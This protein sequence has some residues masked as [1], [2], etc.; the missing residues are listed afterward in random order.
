ML[1]AR[2]ADIGQKLRRAAVLRRGPGQ[3]GK[4]R[5]PGHARFRTVLVSGLDA[6]GLV[7][8]AERDG[9]V[10][11]LQ[12]AV[13]ERRAAIAAETAL[14]RIRTAE[15][16]DPAARD[17]EILERH[18]GRRGAAATARPQRHPA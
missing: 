8:R 1:A 3:T 4:L 15:N 5:E 2:T 18:T 9:D 16:G 13:G 7:Q 11:C 10:A 12:V 14:D 6:L 17:L